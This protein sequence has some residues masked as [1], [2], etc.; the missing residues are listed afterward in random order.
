MKTRT[1]PRAHGVSDLDALSYRFSVQC[2]S[3]LEESLAAL[4]EGL[5]HDGP[6]ADDPDEGC[7][8]SLHAQADGTIDVWRDPVRRWHSRRTMP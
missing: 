2:D 7:C 1:R 4:L 8:Y 3:R 5:R 6:P